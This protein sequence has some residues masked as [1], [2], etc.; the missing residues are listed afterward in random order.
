MR[1]FLPFVFPLLA[2]LIVVYLGMRWYRTETSRN[3]AD[4]K[5]AQFADGAKIEDLSASTSSQLKTPAKD[6]KT[7]DMSGSDN[8]K[9]QI[10]YELK[11]GKVYFSVFADLPELKDGEGV[12]QVWLKQ[13]NGDQKRK[14]FTLENT[15]SGYTGGAAISMDTLPFDVVVTKQQSVSDD[16]MSSTLLSGT[17]E[18]EVK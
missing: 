14:A 17:I 10:R 18:K 5:P 11:D 4:K 15:K 6:E 12:Y 2:L 7:V 3:T 8:A 16:N 1:K 13:V 9:G